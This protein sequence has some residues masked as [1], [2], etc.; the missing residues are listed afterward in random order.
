MSLPHLGQHSG[1]QAG[2]SQALVSAEWQRKD[3]RK[4]EESSPPPI[5]WD[6][7]GVPR[8]FKAES[9]T[10]HG[11]EFLPRLPGSLLHHPP[12]G[13]GTVTPSSGRG[14]GSP[15][16]HRWLCHSILFMVAGWVRSVMEPGPSQDRG[17]KL[18]SSRTS[19]E[20][21]NQKGCV[22]CSN[23]APETAQSQKAPRTLAQVGK[24]RQRAE[25]VM[26]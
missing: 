6:D 21:G 4:G 14:L 10:S 16:C 25:G 18:L 26:Q 2:H 20:A 15:R 12:P 7:R 11:T 22:S 17:E 3:L 24:L 13:R 8:P 9:E 19:P 1:V 23:S 5:N